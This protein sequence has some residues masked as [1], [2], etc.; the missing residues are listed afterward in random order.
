MIEAAGTIEVEQIELHSH[1]LENCPTIS[2]TI[3]NYVARTKQ[4]VVLENATKTG[5]FT[6]DAYVKPQH[7]KSILCVPL[8]NQ[9]K[10]V[11]IVYLENNL[12]TGVFTFTT[13]RVELLNLLSSQAA[14]AIENARLYTNLATLNRAYEHFVPRE[15][16]Q[17]L[18][19]DS[20]TEVK[21][22]D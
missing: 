6:N 19:K 3:V 16:L 4:N 7:P 14:I 20:I 10:L 1:P 5:Q 17:F 15:F 9:G 13:E 21:L 8:I 2:P 11:S 18:E 22:G 12:T